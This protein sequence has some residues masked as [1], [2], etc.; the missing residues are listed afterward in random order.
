MSERKELITF[1]ASAAVG[2]AARERD[3]VAPEAGRGKTAEPTVGCEQG[4]C[5]PALSREEIRVSTGVDSGGP[6][7][8]K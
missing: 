4:L 7:A 1:G 2:G 8:K 3:N 6:K 5:V